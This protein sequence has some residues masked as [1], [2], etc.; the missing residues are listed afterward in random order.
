MINLKDIK[1]D[2]ASTLGDRF[3]LTGITPKYVYAEGEKT[4]KADGTYYNVLCTDRGYMSVRVSVPGE[5]K[6]SV[7]DAAK[8][9]NIRFDGMVIHLYYIDKKVVITV[10]A[11]NIHVLKT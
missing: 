2:V 9:P 1:V 11:E 5:S 10:T 8:N 7:E 3:L 6:I 4:D